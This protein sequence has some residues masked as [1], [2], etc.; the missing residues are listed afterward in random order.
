MRLSVVLA[1]TAVMLSVAPQ[2]LARADYESACAAP[3][4]TISGGSSELI[5]LAA[6][7]TVLLAG[8]EYTGGLSALPAGAVLCVAD[9]ATFTPA[10][11]NN[12]AGTLA[13]QGSATL[14]N[15][16]VASGFTIENAGTTRIESLNAA[17]TLTLKNESGATLTLQGGVALNSGS[18][19]RNE[20]AVSVGAIN[21][22]S[23]STVTND[24]TLTTGSAILAG[25]IENRGTLAVNGSINETSSTA[26]VDNQCLLS[27]DGTWGNGATLTN[28]GVITLADW[29]GNIGAGSIRQTA[30]GVIS[31]SSFHND[32][33]VTG[34]GGFRFTGQTENTGT[35][36]GDSSSDPISFYDTTPVTGSVFDF[37]SGTAENV[38]R[39]AVSVDPDFV[40]AGCADARLQGTADLSVTKAGPLSVPAGGQ[41]SYLVTV[42]NSGPDTATAVIVQDDLPP[43]LTA[44][45]ASD[46]GTVSGT[47]VTWDVGDLAAGDSVQFTLTGT[48]PDSGTLTDTVSGTTTA[49]DSDPA[50]NDGTADAARVTTVVTPANPNRPPVVDDTTAT[51]TENTPVAGEVAISDP[52]GD[53]V[54]VSLAR[55]PANGTVTVDD[56]GHFVYTPNDGFIGTDTFTVAACDNG[57][58]QLCDT[59][60]VT[61]Q[62]IENA[63]SP[64]PSPTTPTPTPTSTDEPVPTTSPTPTA[65]PVFPTTRPPHHGQPALP[66]TGTESWR[67]LLTALLLAGCGAVV[68]IAAR[69]RRKG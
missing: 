35:F 68:L 40:P 19:L 10:W 53:P 17:G 39:T 46:G 4:R 22:A 66:S 56:T 9:S 38:I 58:P 20:G 44:V 45:T 62:V 16:P 15:I 50:N 1:L 32:A 21:V 24:G 2:P 61:I 60:T 63:P 29:L 57:A 42:S 64:T 49:T 28:S 55:P 47:T 67:F 43:E 65:S 18:V 36:T 34:F 52:D 48:A 69:R 37:S 6:G 27:V 51:T 26:V 5:S 41:V 31:G 59:G 54:T 3:T 7:E 30:D 23:G 14:P 25:R 33:T 13:V 12:P 11:A 8:G